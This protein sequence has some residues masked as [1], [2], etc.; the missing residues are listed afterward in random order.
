MLIEMPAGR[1]LLDLLF[2]DDCVVAAHRRK[3]AHLFTEG[4]EAGN[5]GGGSG[6]RTAIRL[7]ATINGMKFQGIGEVSRAHPDQLP[8]VKKL[9]AALSEFRNTWRDDG[10]V[11][12]VC[13]DLRMQPSQR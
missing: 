2:D 10:R 13:E 4:D 5:R 1:G 8:A 6:N 12:G 9:A 7:I 3:F 11:A